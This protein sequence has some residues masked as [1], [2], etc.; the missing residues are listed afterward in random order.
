MTTTLKCQMTADQHQM[1]SHIEK[2]GSHMRLSIRKVGHREDEMWSVQMLTEDA[3]V[4]FPWYETTCC[5]REAGGQAK[6]TLGE[7]L[8]R[9]VFVQ[10]AAKTFGCWDVNGRGGGGGF[11]F[12]VRRIFLLVLYICI[13]FCFAG[14]PSV[15]HLDWT[16]FNVDALVCPIYVWESH[17]CIVGCDQHF[18][19]YDEQ[20]GVWTLHVDGV[21]GA[22]VVRIV[23]PE[24]KE[25]GVDVGERTGRG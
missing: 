16:I 23:R 3:W 5:G 25:S 19:E 18:G 8:G 9:D 10:D 21:D 22:E 14:T 11:G 4:V 17:E 13:D 1:V 20:C 12:S 2:H 6:C 15:L 24:K 7:V